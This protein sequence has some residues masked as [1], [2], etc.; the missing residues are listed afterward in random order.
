MVN[1]FAEIVV[2]YQRDRTAI[3]GGLAFGPSGG[4][5]KR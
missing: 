5:Q 1:S 4:G 3:D 2:Y